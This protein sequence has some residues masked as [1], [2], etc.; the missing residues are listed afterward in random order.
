MAWF[1]LLLAVDA[2]ELYAPPR[3]AS[4][5]ELFD[6]DFDEQSVVLR[7]ALEDHEAMSSSGGFCTYAAL[8]C[9]DSKG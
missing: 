6:V 3:M 1:E 9:K 7:V 8:R 5:T 2:R 4:C